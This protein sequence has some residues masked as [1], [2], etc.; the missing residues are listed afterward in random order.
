MGKSFTVLFTGL[1]GSGK[2]TLSALTAE[3]LLR[4]G[5]KTEILEG[6]YLKNFLYE[7][8]DQFR[9]NNIIN[10]KRI[11]YISKLLNKYGICSLISTIMPYGESREM[12]RKEIENYLEIYLECDIN[13]LRQERDSKGYYKQAAEEKINYLIGV[14]TPY[15][16]PSR[17]DLIIRTDLQ[18]KS[19]CL[20]KIIL[21]LRDRKLINV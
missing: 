16:T 13:I 3:F 18:N 4:L 9:F 8:E 15:E 12:F 5:F 21:L 14:N 20:E 2:T 6:A 11:I 1:S 10:A 17:P 19:D 7:M